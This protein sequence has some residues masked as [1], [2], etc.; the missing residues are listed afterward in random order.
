MFEFST[1]IRVYEF[2]PAFLTIGQI[3]LRWY[4]LAYI[5]G[6]LF[7][8]YFLIKVNK[9]QKFISDN[10]LENFIPYIIFSVIIGGRLGYI[11]F[12]NFSY[13]LQYPLEIL[14]F[15]HGG[16]SFHGGLAG[17]IIG[18]IFYCKKYQIPFFRLSDYLAICAPFGIFLGRIANFINLELYGRVTESKFGMIFPNSDGLP[19]HPSQL[20]EATLE[21]LVLFI[22]LINLYKFT[23]LKKY[24]GFSSGLF[25]LLYGIFRFLLENFREPD[26]QIGLIFDWLSMGQILCLPLI[27]SGIVIIFYSLKKSQ[28]K[29]IEN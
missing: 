7:T 2:N 27:L 10:A 21:G 11:L 1:P 23:N 15:W 16:M 26:Q 28:L 18:M 19:R 4:S 8:Y 3:S 29:K 14:A 20:Y 13:Y 9:K 17:V 6:I 25:L 22:I 24:Y 5:F 12:Y